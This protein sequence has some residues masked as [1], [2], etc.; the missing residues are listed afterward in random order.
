MTAVRIEVKETAPSLM[1]PTNDALS[2]SLSRFPNPSRTYKLL[3]RSIKLNSQ[4]H[5]HKQERVPTPRLSGGTE[6]S[7]TGP[8]SPKTLNQT[9]ANSETRP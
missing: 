8:R 4:E 9:V 6:W 3:K 5:I 2:I 7:R 1:Q